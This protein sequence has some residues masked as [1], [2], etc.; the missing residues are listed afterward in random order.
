MLYIGMLLFQEEI[1]APPFKE[2]KHTYLQHDV[3]L[4]LA[5]CTP[6]KLNLELHV[7]VHVFWS[8]SAC[9]V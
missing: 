5:M 6:S 8:Q 7:S 2:L 9:L 1:S 3:W 4:L